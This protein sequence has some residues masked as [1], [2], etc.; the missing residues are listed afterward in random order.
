[1]SFPWLDHQLRV[2][3]GFSFQGLTEGSGT[4]TEHAG[5]DR[6]IFLTMQGSKRK[7]D[8]LCLTTKCTNILAQTAYFELLSEKINKIK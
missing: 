8:S 2:K 1:M 5:T 3:V 7:Q 4:G 6:N